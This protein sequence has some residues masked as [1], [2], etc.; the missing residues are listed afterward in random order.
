MNRFD[1]VKYALRMK[2][3]EYNSIR[4]DYEL[5][6]QNTVANVAAK[7]KLREEISVLTKEYQE[8]KIK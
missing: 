2:K 7:K 3:A 6:R 4:V 5:L 1:Q 8:S